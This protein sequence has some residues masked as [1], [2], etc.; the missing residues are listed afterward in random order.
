MSMTSTPHLSLRAAFLKAIFFTFLFL[1]LFFSLTAIGI[2]FF[3]Y[4]QITKF[5]TQ[6]HLTIPQLIDTIEVGWYTT[7]FHTQGKINFLVLGTDQ[8]AT[9]GDAP[10]LTDTILLASLNIN[11]GHVSL[12]SLPRDLW[13]EDYVTKI[14]ALY[15]YGKDKYPAEPE[16]FT[17]DV[18]TQLTGVRP[19]H[20]IVLT[21]ET[22]SELI[23]EVGGIDVKVPIGF[24][25]TQFPRPDV[26]VTK[27]HDPQKLYMTIEFKPGIEHMSGARVLEYIRSR[28]S[29]DDEG[30]D[31]AR[32]SRQ[33]EVIL[34][35][36]NTLKNRGFYKDPARVGRLYHFYDQHFAQSLSITELIALGRRLLPH[37]D[38]IS[39][40]EGSPSIYPNDPQGTITH[41]PVQKF[42]NQWVYQ[43]R[44]LSTF[45]KEVHQKLD[46][47]FEQQA[48]P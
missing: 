42:Q 20:T 46:I 39:F 5:T 33:Q 7:V 41:P 31:T 13:S 27:E 9:R 23:D 28:H 35:L 40:S 32:A 2:G 30:T 14:N 38:T 44:D 19:H 47:P 21:L 36:I 24:T 22:L 11:T 10:V 8:L 18:I 1:F 37:L 4:K 15:A 34:A 45:Q 6:A 12:F 25:D 17:R 3:A 26:D 16:K 43:I 29:G 48:T